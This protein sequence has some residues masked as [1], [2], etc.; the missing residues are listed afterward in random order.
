LCTS[1]TILTLI[2]IVIDVSGL[3]YD[4]R[5]LHFFWGC[6]YF[7]K[8]L[9]SCALPEGRTLTTYPYK[10]RHFLRWG[11]TCKWRRRRRRAARYRFIVAADGPMCRCG[12]C[13]NYLDRS[14]PTITNNAQKLK[15]QRVTTR[16]SSS[17]NSKRNNILAE[18]CR[19]LIT[20]K[21]KWTKNDIA[22][23]AFY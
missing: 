15:R 2:I 21:R 22:K 5:S 12:R 14:N 23:N 6:I 8:K 20:L 11:C 3:R 4:R 9:T 1:C 17:S 13:I 18:F 10:L 16:N 7:L 19:I